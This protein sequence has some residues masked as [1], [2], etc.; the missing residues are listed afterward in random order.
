M[1][2]TAADATFLNSL[3]ERLNQ[4]LDNKIR[5]KIN[6]SKKKGAGVLSLRNVWK[7]IKKQNTLSRSLSQNIY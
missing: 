3:N 5:C 4:T 7:R 1:V 6:E 2:F